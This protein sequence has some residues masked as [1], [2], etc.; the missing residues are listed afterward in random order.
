MGYF[1]GRIPFFL[2][3]VSVLNSLRLFDFIDIVEMPRLNHS[4]LTIS[5]EII[6]LAM[7]LLPFYAS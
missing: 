4:V 6:A 3:K 2:V 5:V 7:I 1:V